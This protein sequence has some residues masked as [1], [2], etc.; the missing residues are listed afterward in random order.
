MWYYYANEHKGIC[1]EYDFSKLE[2]FTKLKYI[3]LP[4]I[5]PNQKEKKNYR[6]GIFIRDS[7][8]VSAVRN[9]LVKSRDWNFEKEWRII[10]LEGISNLSIPVK[11]VYLGYNIEEES[12]KHIL[13]LVNSSNHMI[14]LYEM[15]ESVTGLKA[16]K[17]K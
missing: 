14:T 1:L 8:D 7:F 10:C 2:S 9:S 11:N 3:F 13:D 6:T 12:K 4:I 16:E 17:L 15:K 5:Y